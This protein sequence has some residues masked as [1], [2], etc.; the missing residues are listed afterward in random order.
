MHAFSSPTDKLLLLANGIVL[1]KGEISATIKDQ[2]NQHQRTLG[3]KLWEGQLQSK[4]VL[5]LSK[6]LAA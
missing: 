4:G 2:K 1:D 6:T 3:G 5:D